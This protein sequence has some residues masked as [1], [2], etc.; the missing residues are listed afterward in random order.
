VSEKL[1]LFAIRANPLM[2]PIVREYQQIA[3]LLARGKKK[4][5]LK[6]LVRVEA[7]LT[8]LAARMSDIDDYMN[9]FEATQSTT[10]SGVFVDYLRAMSESQIPAP[11]RRDALSVYLDSIA[12]QFDD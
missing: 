4:K 11:R 3:G 10:G 12:E 5:V 6:R 1:V 2:R 9:W 8:T 7:T